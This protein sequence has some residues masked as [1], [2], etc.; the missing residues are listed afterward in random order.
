MLTIIDKKAAQQKRS[1]NQVVLL[2]L[3][4]AIEHEERKTC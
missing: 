1:R 2:M 3:E 4:Q